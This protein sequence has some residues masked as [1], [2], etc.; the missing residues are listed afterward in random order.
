MHAGKNV[1]RHFQFI[2]NSVIKTAI[3]IIAQILGEASA[4]SPPFLPPTNLNNVHILII[5]GS[6][7]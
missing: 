3:I 7:L 6:H 1:S 2:V 4:P 5:L